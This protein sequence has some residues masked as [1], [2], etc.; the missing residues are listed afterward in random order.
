MEA[1]AQDDGQTKAP[2][3]PQQHEVGHGGGATVGLLGQRR[4]VDVIFHGD[5]ALQALA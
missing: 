1:A 2:T 3:D 4:Q 5:R